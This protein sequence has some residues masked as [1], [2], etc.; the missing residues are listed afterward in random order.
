MNEADTKVYQEEEDE[1]DM[2]EPE[3]PQPMS[4]APMEQDSPEPVR[5]EERMEE[6][7]KEES[8]LSV[9]LCICLTLDSIITYVS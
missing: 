8:V 9:R 7:D 1:E 6:R 3:V 2:A 5:Q 4:D